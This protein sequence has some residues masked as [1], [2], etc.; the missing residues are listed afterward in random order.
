M[1]EVPVNQEL[2]MIPKL[3]LKRLL[4]ELPLLSQDPVLDEVLRESRE[5]LGGKV[6][7]LNL[8]TKKEN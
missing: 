7:T 5:L 4:Q 3:L 1:D 6:L 2:V 8:D